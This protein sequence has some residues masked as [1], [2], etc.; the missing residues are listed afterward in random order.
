MVLQVVLAVAPHL[1][2]PVQEVSVARLVQEA[3]AAEHIQ[4]GR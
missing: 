4:V 2:R 1:Q 3:L